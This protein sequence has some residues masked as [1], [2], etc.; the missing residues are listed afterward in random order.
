MSYISCDSC[1]ETK[2]VNPPDT[3]HKEVNRKLDSS[4]DY[5]STSFQ[6]IKCSSFNTLYWYKPK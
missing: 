1:G 2:F 4:Q 3:I 5:V 6:C